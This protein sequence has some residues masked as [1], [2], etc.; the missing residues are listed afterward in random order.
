M[1]CENFVNL[2]VLCDKN[3]LNKIIANK[4]HVAIELSC[5]SSD[6]ATGDEE[7]SANV[8]VKHV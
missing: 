5:E 1:C 2:I 8:F 3:I 7:Q 4:F 6:C